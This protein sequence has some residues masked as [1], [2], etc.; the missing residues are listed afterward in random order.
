MSA[1]KPT[2]PRVVERRLPVLAIVGRPNVGKSTL[3]NR[4][5]RQR[6]AIVDNLP[7]V[8]RDRN[9]GEAEWGAKKFLLVDTG[10]FEA[11]PE[12]ELK[13]KIQEQSRLAMEEADIVLCLFDGKAG[14]SPLDR[15]VARL[16]RH[17]GKPVFFAVNKIDA[18]G[19]EAAIADFYTLG[20]GEVWPLSAEHGQGLDGLMERLA[21]AFPRADGAAAADE[22]NEPRLPSLAVVGR[23]N[24]GKSTLV[25]RLLGYERSIVDSLPG[26]T[27]DSLDTPLSWKGE[28]YL[29]VD[30]AGV[31]RKAR[32]AD[33]VERYSVI[34]SLGALDRSDVALYLL[35]GAEGATS[36]D[37]QV[38]A[39]AHRRGKGI[40]LGV[41]K[42]D[43]VDGA[44]VRPEAYKKELRARLAFVDYAPVVLISA[45]IGYGVD[46]LMR[47][48][49]R[50]ARGRARRVQ[51]AAVNR[52]L[53]ELVKTHQPPL[54]RGR[55]VKFYY[56]TQ[57]GVGPPTLTL[58]V[59]WPRA[60]EASYLRYLTD[61]L[62][63]LL[64]FD[65]APLRLALKPRRETAVKKRR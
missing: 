43:L 12:T 4:L 30:T 5:V 29:L 50:V 58:F 54:Y 65:A 7:G 60:I 16:M 55:P 61:R 13:R 18:A 32:I 22:E 39:Y 35:D 33:R 1:A 27:R 11:A 9:Y 56:G 48:A 17:A 34:R 64:G 10:G 46:G 37:A 51:T 63:E 3:F 59:N 36:Q 31:R 45:R 57:T 62:R 28:R 38:L 20:L 49:L 44:S 19:G 6:R 24:V 40:V 2:A 47:A 25:N 21:E 52:A 14:V 26:T 8:T 41:N 42:W 53:Q 23:P 15:E